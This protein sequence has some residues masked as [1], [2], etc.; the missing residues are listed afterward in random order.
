MAAQRRGRGGWGA[1]LHMHT[2]HLPSPVKGT[3]QGYHLTASCDRFN[4]NTS[5]SE[6]MQSD[7]SVVYNESIRILRAC[8]EPVDGI[9]TFNYHVCFFHN[10]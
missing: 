1:T 8:V 7:W 10:F 9:Y 3:I 6:I 4:L 5:D 2:L